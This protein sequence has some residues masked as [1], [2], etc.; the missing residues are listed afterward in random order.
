MGVD[1]V[2]LVCLLSI[3]KV[4]V[5]STFPNFS[6]FFWFLF[7]GKNGKFIP[8]KILPNMVKFMKVF[9]INCKGCQHNGDCTGPMIMDKIPTKNLRIQVK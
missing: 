1:L 6:F 7:Q 4:A 9:F 5:P 3:A 8:S 2:W